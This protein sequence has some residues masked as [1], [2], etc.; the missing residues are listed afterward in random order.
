MTDI[1]AFGDVY[2]Q[3]VEGYDA[4]IAFYVSEAPDGRGL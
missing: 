2:D 4:D 3:M 1:Y